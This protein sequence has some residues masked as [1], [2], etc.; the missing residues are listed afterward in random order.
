MSTEVILSEV[1]DRFLDDSN[2]TKVRPRTDLSQI[3]MTP[4]FPLFHDTKKRCSTNYLKFERSI[5][6]GLFSVSKIT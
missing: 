1:R 6:G 2:L 4:K 5:Q 3:V